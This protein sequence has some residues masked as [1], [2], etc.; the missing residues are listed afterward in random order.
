[1]QGGSSAAGS[2]GAAALRASSSLPAGSAAPRGGGADQSFVFAEFYDSRCAKQALETLQIDGMVLPGSP[3]R[4]SV[5]E[6]GAA[7]AA[8]PAGV[9]GPGAGAAGRT[10]NAG[11]SSGGPDPLSVSLFDELPVH[12]GEDGKL[13]A[14]L[15]NSWWG[16]PSSAWSPARGAKQQQQQSQQ[17]AQVRTGHGLNPLQAQA[18]YAASQSGGARPAPLAPAPAGQ[19]RAA[20]RL[21][22]YAHSGPGGLGASGNGLDTV[23]LAGGSTRPGVPVHLQGLSPGGGGGLGA[24]PRGLP[25]GGMGPARGDAGPGAGGHG[26]R[27]G[28]RDACGVAAGVGRASGLPGEAPGQPPLLPQRA[29]PGGDG[30]TAGLLR[31]RGCRDARG[32]GTG[33][34]RR[35]GG[36]GPRRR[37]CFRRRGRGCLPA[38][39]RR[40]PQQRGPPRDARRL[41]EGGRGPRTECRWSARSFWGAAGAC[42]ATGEGPWAEAPASRAFSKGGRGP[43]SGYRTD[44]RRL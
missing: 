1:M 3:P 28:C 41:R 8:P 34:W 15:G 2:S 5:G 43:G 33:S 20:A 17:Q 32:G 9:A 31:P 35:R 24:A 30:R 38:M 6:G 14:G 39:G 37:T 18:A 29:G 10:G 25:P 7:A 13:H 23:P 36:G 11:G 16:Q 21:E 4:A 42:A 12:T 44:G 22:G 19:H 40:G 27:A 26:R